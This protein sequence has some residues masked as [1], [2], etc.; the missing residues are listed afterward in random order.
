MS[1]RDSKALPV[2]LQ[3]RSWPN[4]RTDYSSVHH[5]NGQ[6]ELFSRE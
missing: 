1:E 4:Q 6:I 5:S 3:T 2:D